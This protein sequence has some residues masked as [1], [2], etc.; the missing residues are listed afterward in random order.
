MNTLLICDA[1]PGGKGFFRPRVPAA[2]VP[3]FGRSSIDRALEQIH[4]EGGAE[5]IVLASDRPHLVR[6]ALAS[7]SHWGMRVQVEAVES[8]LS[9]DVARLRFSDGFATAGDI[10]VRRLSESNKLSAAAGAEPGRELFARLLESGT[11][12]DLVTM[13]QTAPGIWASSRARVHPAAKLVAPVW[14]GPSVRIAAGAEIGPGTIIEAGA[15]VEPEARLVAAWIGPDTYVGRG[16][17]LVEAEVWGSVIQ[18]KA[19][20]GLLDVSDTFVLADLRNR[21]AEATGLLSRGAAAMLLAL[22]LPVALPWM[23]WRVMRKRPVF[24]PREVHLSGCGRGVPSVRMLRSLAEVSGLR[25]R[26][27]EL[28]EVLCGRMRLVG[29]RPLPRRSL[30]GLGAA[31]RELWTRKPSG[32]FSLAD[33]ESIDG[34]RAGA[35]QSHAAWFTTHDRPGL[36][37]S[38][39]FRCLFRTLF[40]WTAP[41]PKTRTQT[42][43]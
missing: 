29:N 16:A 30:A 26:W 43:S 34:D 13:R 22:T 1:T 2:L 14:I 20:G 25:S 17:E 38:I 41:F 21:G 8:V 5:V 37:A 36:R 24:I 39:F 40:P 3:V 28:F 6:A 32:I 12:P 23:L 42:V 19:G 18:A 33:A 31:R 4:R 35:A 15:L 10:S 9:A 27:P 7:G 11:Q